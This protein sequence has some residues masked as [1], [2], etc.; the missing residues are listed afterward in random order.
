[1]APELSASWSPPNSS[2]TYRATGRRI[3]SDA[4]K[5]V[6]LT[7]FLICDPR[8]LVRGPLTA[9]ADLPKLLA[10]R[11]APVPAATRSRHAARSRIPTVRIARRPAADPDPATHVRVARGGRS[12]R[13]SSS[14][15]ATQSAPTGRGTGARAGSRKRFA[16]PRTRGRTVVAVGVRARVPVVDD[17]PPQV[18]LSLSMHHRVE[19]FGE[20]VVD[21]MQQA[22][23]SLVFLPFS[24]HRS[25]SRATRPTGSSPPTGA[26]SPRSLVREVARLLDRQVAFAP[27]APRG[28]GRQRC[29]CPLQLR[30]R[31]RAPSDERRTRAGR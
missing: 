25:S 2:S 29:A 11:D 19:P 16:D 27:T 22:A 5:G 14:P 30:R 9:T 28:Q 13:S 26:S 8:G 15:C 1:M 17:G 7:A 3:G 21:A 12:R 10:H 31:R 18:A 4:S 23:S 20:I 6:P 24:E